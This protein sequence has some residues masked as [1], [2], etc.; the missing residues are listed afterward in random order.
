M[1]SNIQGT[2][3]EPKVNEV[4]KVIGLHAVVGQVKFELIHLAALMSVGGN[5][6]E[7]QVNFIA[8]QLIQQYPNETLADFKL[9]FQRGAIGLYGDIQRMDG[10]TI[11]G[12]MKMYLDEKY[13]FLEDKLMKEKDNPYQPIE[14][15]PAT[16]VQ[17]APP[18]VAQKY[19]DEMKEQFTGRV[20]EVGLTPEEIKKEGKETP[21]RKRGTSYIPQPE[22]WEPKTWERSMRQWIKDE[23]GNISE[24]K[25]LEILEELKSTLKP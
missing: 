14:P 11:G 5:L 16:E 25:V 21:P 23:Y 10:I 6:N 2:F 17:P 3:D 24:F 12:W 20:Q 15:V 22:T 9:C 8:D 4:V 1:P 18:E 7:A 19:I 13:Q